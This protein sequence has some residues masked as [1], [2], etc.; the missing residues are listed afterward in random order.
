MALYPIFVEMKGR[1]ILV[2]GGGHV[3]A[4]KVRGLLAGEADITLVSPALNDELRDHVEAGRIRHIERAY[5]DS[6]LD[7][8]YELIMVATDDG[9]INAEV[10]ST[11]SLPSPSRNSRMSASPLA[12]A[13]PDCT[14]RP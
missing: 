13:I 2:I 12:A 8:G 6:D 11:R 10:H 3:S 1:R 14:A 9:A 5:Q 4:E 7:G